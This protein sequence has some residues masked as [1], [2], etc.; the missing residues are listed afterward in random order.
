MKAFLALAVLTLSGCTTAPPLPAAGPTAALGG[1]AD[2][3]GVLIRPISV[4]EDSRCPAD[5]VCVWAGRL[6]IL[7]EVEWPGS[8]I[9]RGPL[10]LG[11]PYAHG[12]EAVTLIAAHPNKLS[13]TPVKPANYRFTFAVTRSR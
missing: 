10:T 6:I 3:D 11:E 12:S 5:V 2:V 1:V 7:A 8:E 9:W 4:V 13:T